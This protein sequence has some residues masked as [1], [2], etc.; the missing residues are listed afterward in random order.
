MKEKDYGTPGKG[1]EYAVDVTIDNESYQEWYEHEL[2]PVIK[3]KM[4]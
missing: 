4:P 1:E 2:L 3:E